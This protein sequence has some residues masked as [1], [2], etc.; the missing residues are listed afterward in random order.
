MPHIYSFAKQD[1]EHFDFAPAPEKILIGSPQQKVENIYTGS[2]GAFSVGVWEG[3]IGKWRVSYSEE[4]Y[5]ELLEGVVEVASSDG[6]TKRFK[7]GDR[8]V[9]PA[10]F[11]GTWEVLEKARKVYV[12]YEPQPA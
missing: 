6:V 8:F 7:A 11:K 2:N 1:T 3:E 10:G 9:I 5:C 4:E 12:I